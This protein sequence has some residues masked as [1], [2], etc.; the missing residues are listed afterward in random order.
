MLTIALSLVPQ[1]HSLN[2]FNIDLYVLH[3]PRYTSNTRILQP[4]SSFSNAHR[5]I[6]EWM[7]DLMK[8]HRTRRAIKPLAHVLMSIA[9]H[10][11]L[12]QHCNCISQQR[13]TTNM[14]RNAQKKNFFNNIDKKWKILKSPKEY[15][16]NHTA[17]NNWQ[18]SSSRAKNEKRAA[19]NWSCRQSITQ[20]FTLLVVKYSKTNYFT[21][22][23]NTS[24]NYIQVLH[25]NND[26][27]ACKW[28]PLCVNFV[29][30]FNSAQSHCL[31]N[32][33][34]QCPR[35][36]I[37]RGRLKMMNHENCTGENAGPD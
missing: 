19:E 1:S 24:N 14:A 10:S 21:I 30:G 6:N 5:W 9:S 29:T 17:R 28:T 35:S 36:D 15:Q 8:N 31:L 4:F 3:L 7:K 2:V 25:E 22:I 32:V 27:T 18:N 23:I 16:K 11:I 13:K 34:S 12:L 20:T 37:C 33:N 26:W